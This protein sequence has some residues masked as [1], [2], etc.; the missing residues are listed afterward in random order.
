MVEREKVIMLATLAVLGIQGCKWN[1]DFR[2]REQ[3][4][5]LQ[6]PQ[7]LEPPPRPTLNPES[8]DYRGD[9]THQTEDDERNTPMP[10]IDGLSPIP[11]VPEHPAGL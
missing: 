6:Q 5:Y 8:E 7:Y 3:P 10:A 2:S 4:G 9:D 11:E 1:D